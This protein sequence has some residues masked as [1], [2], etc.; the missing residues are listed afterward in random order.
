MG[1]TGGKHRQQ[2]GKDS[3]ENNQLSDNIFSRQELKSPFS[4]KM[5]WAALTPNTCTGDEQRK[6]KNK[7][8]Q[9]KYEIKQF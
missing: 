5:V 7:T 1:I 3:Q 9:R 4:K 2:S 8:I 6:F